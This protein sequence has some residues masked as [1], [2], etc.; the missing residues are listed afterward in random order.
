MAIHKSHLEK[1]V[2][3]K[4]VLDDE[5]TLHMYAQDQSFVKKC[6]PDMVV[7]AETV[8]QIQELVRLA[9]QTKTPITPFSSGLNLHGAAIPDQGGIILNM[10]KMNTII[11]IDQENWFAVI[12]PGVTYRQ[13]QEELVEKGFR[14]MVPFGAH[15]GR[16]VLTS[17]M[18]RDVVLAAPNFE[19]GTSLIMD[20]EIVLPTGDIFRTGNWTCGGS[21]G[22]PAGPVRTL[23][24][25]LWT[26]A[27]GTFG[28][29]TKIGL[30]I[31]P[32]PALRKIY[33]MPFQETGHA[34]EAITKIQRKEIGL[35]CFLLN[36][37]NLAAIY[38]ENW[39]VPQSFPVTHTPSEEFNNLRNSLP[40]FVLVL[41][42]D[43]GQRHP[44]DKIPYEEKARKEVCSLLHVDS[45]FANSSSA[46][47]FVIYQNISSSK[48]GID[49][50]G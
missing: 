21:P 49:V 12:E 18:E 2:G 10:S 6:M 37:F 35:E 1:I 30:Q 7:F 39:Q 47:N 48:G 31:E 43:G 5:E 19:R 22:S 36:N 45:I 13:L 20:T 15:P 34:A 50:D 8:E 14:M 4:N 9:N 38:T 29:I 16:S 33:F 46:R 41:C 17:Y 23:I 26:G 40:P 27:Q 42:I 32:L 24:Y 25:R 3:K 44:E 11:T 28:I